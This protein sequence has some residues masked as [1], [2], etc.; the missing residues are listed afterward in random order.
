LARRRFADNQLEK[1]KDSWMIITNLAGVTQATR[2]DRK[3]M[4]TLSY[5]VDG[6]K[7]KFFFE[8]NASSPT[9]I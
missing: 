7:L 6:G 5:P 1:N 8:G 3:Q 9:P 2:M 4:I